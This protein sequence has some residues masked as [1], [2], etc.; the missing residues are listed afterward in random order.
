[1]A[2]HHEGVP[3]PAPGTF[4]DLSKMA[5]LSH[6]YAWAY[7]YLIT[8]LDS[9]NHGRMAPGSLAAEYEELQREVA[10]ACERLLSVQANP[11]LTDAATEVLSHELA[12][13]LDEEIRRHGRKRVILNGPD[14]RP[15]I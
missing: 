12:V 6:V 13:T 3:S 11:V 10:A 15:D 5:E 1:M 8:M 14:H 2:T 7:G 9:W 4:D